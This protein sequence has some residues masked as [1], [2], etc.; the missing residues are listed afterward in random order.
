MIITRSTARNFR[1][2]RPDL[3]VEW[4]PGINLVLGANGSGKTNL[5]ETLSILTGW[6]AFS[7]TQNVI[8]WD[9]KFPRAFVGAEVSGEEKFTVTANISSRVAL[10]VDD[11]AITSTELRLLLPSV[12]FLTGNINLIDGSPSARRLFVDRLCSLFFPIYARRLAEFKY[13]M[14]SR[15]ALLRQGRNY[16]I[17]TIPYCK[18]GGWIMDRRREVV[19][20]LMGMITPG[21]FSLSC[22]PELKVPGEEYLHEMLRA[23]RSRELHALRPQDGANYDELAITITEN[24]RS[25]SEALSRGQKRRLVLY[26]IIMAGK[27]TALK[28]KREPILLF[29]DLTAELDGE[30]REWTYT[31]L[32]KTKWQV[33]MTSPEKPF[34]IR[35][36]FGGIT[37]GVP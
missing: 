1:N 26:M 3:Y 36:K 24:G 23:N 19:N 14:R 13:V 22:V 5:L 28:L 16:E 20:M 18:L 4:D 32:K 2:L 10:R 37:L 25:A 11:K 21:K 9:G 35:K 31:Q 34:A 30:G 6:G 33:F 15:I 27:L 12:V 7:R 8:S 29:D 17:T